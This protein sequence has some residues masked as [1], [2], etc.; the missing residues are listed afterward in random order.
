[1]WRTNRARAPA[2]IKVMS[3]NALDIT[4]RL[5]Y[6]VPA[7]RL[8]SGS[9]RM[10]TTERRCIAHS[11]SNDKAQC[12]NFAVRGMQVCRMH[13]GATPTAKQAAKVRLLAMCEPAFEVLHQCMQDPNAEWADKIKAANSVLDRAGFTAKQQ[14]TVK[15]KV[16]DLDD[17]S[18][19]EKIARGRKI[20]DI[21][22]SRKVQVID[23]AVEES[24][25]GVT[26]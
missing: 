21:L 13:G 25:T 20:L 17:M 7:P 18:D 15:H 23:V 4:T 1:V 8:E 22:E 6:T 2:Y 26:P 9:R 3:S 24:A 16:Q 14:M 12:K 19:D 5:P 11:T 10:D